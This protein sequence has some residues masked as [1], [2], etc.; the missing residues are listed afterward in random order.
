M[1]LQVLTHSSY[2]G[3]VVASKFPGQIPYT[4]KIVVSWK[5]NA[6]LFGNDMKFGKRVTRL[7]VTIYCSKTN[8]EY[9]YSIFNFFKLIPDLE[10]S[11]TS[12]AI[13]NSYKKLS[14]IFR[15]LYLKN[16]KQSSNRYF[17]KTCTM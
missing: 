3:N 17:L 5:V 10:A 1:L 16:H 13:R 4:Q 12:F 2:T 9:L 6:M 8:A 15:S 14:S 7:G 11:G